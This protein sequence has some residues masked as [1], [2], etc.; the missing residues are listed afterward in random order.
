MRNKNVCKHPA[1]TSVKKKVY[2]FFSCYKCVRD[3]QNRYSEWKSIRSERTDGYV[4]FYFDYMY[5]QD[6]P[7]FD[8]V[9]SATCNNLNVSSPLKAFCH[10]DTLI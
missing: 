6:L 10:L 9:L 7:N 2:L 8:Y 4:V 3:D 5:K 1:L